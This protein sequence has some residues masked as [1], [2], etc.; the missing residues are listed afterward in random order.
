MLDRHTATVIGKNEGEGAENKVMPQDRDGPVTH[1]R[2]AEPNEG[3]NRRRSPQTRNGAGPKHGLHADAVNDVRRKLGHEPVDV[4]YEGKLVKGVGAGPSERNGMERK[5][6]IRQVAHRVGIPAAR[7]RIDGRCNVNVIAR[8]LRG[9]GERQK[10]RNKKRCIDRNDK[11]AD[12]PR[13]ALS[14]KRRPPASWL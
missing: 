4:A 1:E 9:L 10:V 13:A 8:T 14:R 6:Q 11:K 5:A 3:V 12:A 2:Q 7:L